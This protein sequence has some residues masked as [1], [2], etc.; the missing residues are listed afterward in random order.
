M[1]KVSKRLESI[2][3]Q[4]DKNKLYSLEEAF[5]QA[6]NLATAKFDESLDVAFQLGVDPKH[7][8][9]MVRGSIVLPNGTGKKVK[10]LV[11]T[12]GEN[13]KKAEQAN[14]DYVGGEE[15][16]TKISGGWMEF[17]KIIATMDMMPKLSKLS[18]ILGPKGL[19]PNPKLG[20]VTQD[21]VK[22]IEEQKA[23]KVD[24][25]TEKNGV[26]HILIGKKSFGL[27]KL[28]ENFKVILQAILRAKPV[29][30][31]GIYL[32]G[33]SISSSMGPGIKLNPV[34]FI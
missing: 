24:F 20:T 9:Q 29:T 10:I 18:K 30:S 25:R 1:K 6:I 16:I 13:I 19:M 15:F 3:K 22:A 28:L 5:T 31:K 12:S 34:E 21:V 11:L 27:E 23:G 17:D 32:K 7:A 2:Q 33:V 26:V 4:I 8:D 14:A